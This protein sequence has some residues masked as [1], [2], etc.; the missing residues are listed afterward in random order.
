M[1]QVAIRRATRSSTAPLL[2]AVAIQIANRIVGAAIHVLAK[3]YVMCL[4]PKN[5]QNTKSAPI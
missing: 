2:A 5:A 4:K 3:V 1:Q